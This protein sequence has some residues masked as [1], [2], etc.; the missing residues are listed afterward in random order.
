[1]AEITNHT[2]GFEEIFQLLKNLTTN[3]NEW[4][5][6]NENLALSVIYVSRGLISSLSDA[7]NV[8]KAIAM[9]QQFLIRPVNIDTCVVIIGKCNGLNVSE[10]FLIIN[11]FCR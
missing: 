1:M 6:K 2:L 8:L 11:I 3:D 7:L 10:C 9:G 4:S 5:M